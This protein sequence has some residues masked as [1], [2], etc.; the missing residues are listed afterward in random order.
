MVP[1]CKITECGYVCTYIHVCKYVWRY[2]CTYIYVEVYILSSN[3]KNQW[4]LYLNPPCIFQ[5][6]MKTWETKSG[7]KAG[8]P[9]G[10]KSGELILKRFI[11]CF[12]LLWKS[13]IGNS[14]AASPKPCP[15]SAPACQGMW[16]EKPFNAHA[17]LSP[18]ARLPATAGRRMW[19][20]WDGCG[21]C[22]Q[23]PP[24]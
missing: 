21:I 9:L 23:N 13:W 10:K 18:A 19:R 7:C 11:G 8:N 12:F 1:K 15:E 6:K 3:T 22:G 5:V 17:D 20:S 2:K 16:W 24:Y 4:I 14:G